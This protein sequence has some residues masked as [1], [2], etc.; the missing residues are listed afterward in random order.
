MKTINACLAGALC[1]LALPATAMAEN[2]KT[3]KSPQQAATWAC[4]AERNGDQAAFKAR[5][6]S[7]TPMRDCRRAQRSEVAS[8]LRAARRSCAAE[9]KKGRALGKCKAAKQK[10]TLRAFVKSHR[11]AA[12]TCKAAQENEAAFA[13]EWGNEANAFGKC[14]SE[15]AKKQ[16]EGNGND[17]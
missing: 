6:D 9:G 11:N 1:A 8:E 12:K 13:E 7:K 4:K 17:E 16:R 14:V 2:H 5:Y 15:T 10:Q 3:P